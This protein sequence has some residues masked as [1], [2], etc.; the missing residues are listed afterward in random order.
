MSQLPI[1]VAAGTPHG[2]NGAGAPTY[3]TGWRAGDLLLMFVET[4]NEAMSTPSGWNEVADSPQ[5]VAGD[6][7]LT[8]YYRRAQFSDSTTVS[9]T[10]PGNHTYSVILAFRGVIETGDPWDV[11]SGGTDGVSNTSVSIGGD[12]TTVANCLVVVACA[13]SADIGTAEFASW[14]NSDLANIQPRSDAGTTQG[15][16]GGIGIITGEKVSAGSYGPTTASL[17][18][19]AVKA[20]MTI[21]LKPAAAPWFVA[22]GTG[23]GSAGAVSVPWPTNH[24]ADDIGI[25]LIDSENETVATPSG[26]NDILNSPQG[27]GTAG[28]AGSTRL[29]AFWRRATGSSESDASVGDSGNH[30]VGAIYVFRNVATSGDPWDT[31]TGGV[32]ASATTT[33]TMTGVTPSVTNTLILAAASFSTDISAGTPQMSAW[34]NATLGG[35]FG[36]LFEFSAS[37]GSGG[38]VG[39]AAGYLASASA[40]GTSTVT[41]ATSSTSGWLTIALRPPVTATNASAETSSGTGAANNATTTVAVGGT[42]TGAGTG[43]A[44]AATPNVGPVTLHASGTGAANDASISTIDS[45]QAEHAAGTGAANDAAAS[46][47]AT[48]GHAAGTGEAHDATTT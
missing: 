19:T 2:T 14:A 33:V 6:T 18:T 1:F 27:T 48:A 47:A 8:V 36:E 40:S 46:V 4:S 43:A 17:T 42:G 28:S 10:D 44:N 31:T 30:Q 9:L 32:E 7:R 22:N 35:T 13:R 11:T 39:M 23:A 5:G 25:L 45:A 20:F 21:A 37:A 15:N 3:P 24:Q 41:L 34:S 16:G 29:S 26:W 38:G 12:T